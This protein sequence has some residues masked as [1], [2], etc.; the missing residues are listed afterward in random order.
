MPSNLTEIR[1]FIAS[2]GDMTPERDRLIKIIQNFNQPKR[3]ISELGLRVQALD[4]RQH[5]VPQ[6][7]LP[8]EVILKQLPPDTWNI[9]VGLMWQR[10]GS[11]TG[12][13]KPDSSGLTFDSGTLQ[14]FTTAYD[15]WKKHGRPEILFYRCMR[16]L[17]PDLDIEQYQK[18]REFFKQFAPGGAHPGFI[19]EFKETNEFAE[20]VER[21]LETILF[22][23]S[24]QKQANATAGTSAK[25]E[26]QITAHREHDAKIKRYLD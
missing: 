25:L 20:L 5:V 21:H 26:E 15:L 12:S 11:D 24:K 4:W 1:I 14:E 2:P 18:V 17:D 3:I 10:F 19:K 8:E 23:I 22:E 7:G 6:M 16:P 13:L 9:F